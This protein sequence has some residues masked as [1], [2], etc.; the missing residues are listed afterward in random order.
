LEGD[1]QVLERR[2]SGSW[3]ETLGFLEGDTQA[4]GR[5]YSGS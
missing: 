3:K 4:P 2:H 5:R 1:T